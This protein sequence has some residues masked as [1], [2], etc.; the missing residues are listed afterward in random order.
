MPL[1][2]IPPGLRMERHLRSGTMTNCIQRTRTSHCSIS[3]RTRFPSCR[4]RMAL[5]APRWSPDGNYVIA[6][7]SGNG[8]LTLY[9]TKTKT[10]RTVHSDLFFGYLSWSHDSAYIYFDTVLSKESGYYRLRVSDGK[11][12]KIADLKKA[13]LYRGQFG[14]GSW[15]GL[16]PGDVPLFPRDTGT[17]EIY[18]FD[19]QLP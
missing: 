13:R 15:T 7:T 16:G 1:R 3:R 8:K 9:N 6:I 2:P 10:W 11:V 4:D 18:A 14:P 5:F 19:L 17:Q 12:E